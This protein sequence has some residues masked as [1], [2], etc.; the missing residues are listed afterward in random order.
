M[1]EQVIPNQLNDLIESTRNLLDQQRTL[2]KS[3]EKDSTNSKT[4]LHSI[5]HK[6]RDLSFQASQ[7]E[8]T[9]QN[10][11]KKSPD[12]Q[13]FTSTVQSQLKKALKKRNQTKGKRV[14]K[15]IEPPS[16]SSFKDFPIPFGSKNITG[17]RRQLNSA[18]K[19]RRKRLQ[20]RG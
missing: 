1:S 19:K 3:M 5:I 11:L 15:C 17:I 16:T 18:L 6:A 7:L 14:T 2:K 9:L 12:Y 13:P 20:E 4:L 8:R 10:T